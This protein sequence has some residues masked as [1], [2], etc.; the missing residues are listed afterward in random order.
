MKQR[1]N[2]ATTE[3]NNISKINFVNLM[4]STCRLSY[5]YEWMTKYY[6][7]E[8]RLHNHNNG[9]D[10]RNI[11]NL[12]KYKDDL[13][14]ELKSEK[15]DEIIK[16]AQMKFELE[17][18]SEKINKNFIIFCKKTL[19]PEIRMAASNENEELNIQYNNMVVKYEN[20]LMALEPIFTNTED[21]IYETIF[22]SLLKNI[23]IE[24]IKDVILQYEKFITGKKTEKECIAHGISYTENKYNAPKGLLNFMLNNK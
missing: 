13:L 2:H 3:T 21:K 18:I 4:E 7:N 15:K 17:I 14:L 19:A 10:V 9:S 5:Y 11:D 20:E 24:T 12:N 23:S 1:R 22:T 8:I 16:L 6:K